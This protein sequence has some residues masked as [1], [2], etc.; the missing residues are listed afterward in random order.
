MIY[1]HS[2]Y[3]T[4]EL[5]HVDILRENRVIL[6]KR[7]TAWY[8]STSSSLSVQHGTLSVI[9]NA[10]FLSVWWSDTCQNGEA[11]HGWDCIKGFVPVSHICMQ[12]PINTVY[13]IT[14]GL[15]DR[16]CKPAVCLWRWSFL[17]FTPLNWGK[18]S[19]RAWRSASFMHFSPSHP[20]SCL[21][22]MLLDSIYRL[23]GTVTIAYLGG[24]YIFLS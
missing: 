18:C 3:V 21:Y 8:Y 20:L 15:Q 9:L 23:T 1:K 12:S 17:F 10:Y 13:T 24:L 16:L 4:S 11:S 14:E 19:R 7:I 22:L 6:N 5:S 2:H